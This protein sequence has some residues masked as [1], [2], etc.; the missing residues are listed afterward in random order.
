MAPSQRKLQ[1]KLLRVVSHFRQ[2]RQALRNDLKTL[3][4]R[5][6][7]LDRREKDLDARQREL[8][9]REKALLEQF[10]TAQ[11]KGHVSQPDPV[12]SIGEATPSASGAGLKTMPIPEI[13]PF[14]YAQARS[15]HQTRVDRGRESADSE[16]QLEFLVPLYP[17]PLQSKSLRVYLCY[18]R[19]PGDELTK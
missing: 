17:T 8:V 9:E 16:F 10:S 11:M 12:A 14:L 19:S 5:G 4:Q 13:N 18:S 3:V 15:Q 6:A 1:R 7:A 2:Q